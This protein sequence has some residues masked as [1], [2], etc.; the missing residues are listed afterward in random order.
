MML[1]QSVGENTADPLTSALFLILAFVIAG[2]AQTVWFRSRVSQRLDIPLD[3]GMTC[4]GRRIFGDNKTL[5]GFVIM[6]PAAA[7]AFFFLG[8]IVDQNPNLAAR[9]WPMSL[10][11]YTM[12]G[13]WAGLG[14]MIGELPNSFLKRQ[15]GILPG[16]APRHPCA[17]VIFFVLDR[18]DSIIGMLI[19]VSLAVPTHWL[20][21]L[22]LATIGPLVHWFFS[23]IMY[24]CGVKERPA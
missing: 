20:T 9:M 5:R 10:P 14:F 13:M 3:F 12:L 2:S 6:L 11:T 4:R 15:L 8:L 24:W 17:K 1:V 21:W 16:R 7:G 18:F 22:Y 23:V 19:A